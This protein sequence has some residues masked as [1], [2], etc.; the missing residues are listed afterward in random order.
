MTSRWFVR[1]IRFVRSFGGDNVLS[2]RRLVHE[3]CRFQNVLLFSSLK[4]R[5]LTHS[6]LPC[7]FGGYFEFDAECFPFH[8]HTLGAQHQSDGWGKLRVRLC[9]KSA[10]SSTATLFYPISQFRFRFV[11]VVWKLNSMPSVNQSAFIHL[12]CV[13]DAVIHWYLNVMMIYDAGLACDE[14]QNIFSY[15]QDFESLSNLMHTLS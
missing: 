3:C 13:C 9:D 7:L 11:R 15:V 12:Q 1:L 8:A 2:A 6:L 5:C 14:F 10:H 4:I